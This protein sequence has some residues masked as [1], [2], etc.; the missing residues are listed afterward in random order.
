MLW[1]R[2]LTSLRRLRRTS[3]AKTAPMLLTPELSGTDFKLTWT[4]VSN[5]TYRVEFNPDL[6]ISNWTALPGD[7]IGG[8]AMPFAPGIS[9]FEP[10]VRQE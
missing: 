5:V 2:A 3:L 4:V 9:P 1:I 7:V 8:F 10:I 6:T